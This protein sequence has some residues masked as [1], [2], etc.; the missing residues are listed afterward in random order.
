MGEYIKERMSGEARPRPQRMVV[1]GGVFSEDGRGRT[2]TGPILSNLIITPGKR[3]LLSLSPI[4]Y[5]D[6]N[7]RIHEFL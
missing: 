5:N 2:W 7:Y 4:C 6:Q 1:G 3:M